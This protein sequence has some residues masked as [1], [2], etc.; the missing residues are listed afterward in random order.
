[1]KRGARKHILIRPATAVILGML[2]VAT[3]VAVAA[4]AGEPIGADDISVERVGS[5]TDAC[6]VELKE[7]DLSADEP[8]PVCFDV[9]GPEGASADDLPPEIVQREVC[10]A[11]KPGDPG[12]ETEACTRPNEYFGDD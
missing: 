7:P 5:G 6:H 12:L 11:M 10:E 1:M 2:T 3:V 4:V 9:S 8:E